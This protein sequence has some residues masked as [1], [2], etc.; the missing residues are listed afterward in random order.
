M[1]IQGF[2]IFALL[3]LME[4][5]VFSFYF[6]AFSE[7][8]LALLANFNKGVNRLNAFLLCYD[9]SE[10]IDILINMLRDCLCANLVNIF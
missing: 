3:F 5:T 8:M 9:D 1:G 4:T 6:S 2:L 7:K 10:I